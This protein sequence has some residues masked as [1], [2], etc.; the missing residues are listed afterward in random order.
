MHQ[1]ENKIQFLTAEAPEGVDS[2]IFDARVVAET[3]QVQLSNE[4]ANSTL[5]NDRRRWPRLQIVVLVTPSIVRA[6]T[7]VC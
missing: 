7:V 6:L 2:L 3:Q 1:V 4:V 5:R